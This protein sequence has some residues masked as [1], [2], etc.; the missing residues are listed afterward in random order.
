MF[1]SATFVSREE[2]QTYFVLKNAAIRDQDDM[3]IFL[4]L[5]FWSSIVITIKIVLNYQSCIKDAG[6]CH[7]T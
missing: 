4:I 7:L 1:K 3:N 5:L 6:H 2:I